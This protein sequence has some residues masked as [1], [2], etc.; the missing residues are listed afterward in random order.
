MLTI[1]LLQWSLDGNSSQIRRQDARAT[2][3]NIAS[4]PIGQ[5]MVFQFILENWN[6]MVLK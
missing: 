1:R 5:Q 3:T 4:N 2:L 6:D